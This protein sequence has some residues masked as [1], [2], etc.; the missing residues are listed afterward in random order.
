MV[1]TAVQT[2][3]RCHFCGTTQKG[4]K[5]TSL[6]DENGIPRAIHIPVTAV[7]GK[8]ADI[9]P[10]CLKGFEDRVA[11]AQRQRVREHNEDMALQALR[12]EGGNPSLLGPEMKELVQSLSSRGKPNTQ[13]EIFDCTVGDCSRFFDSEAGRN[14][15]LKG[16]K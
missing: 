1:G 3:R 16:H 7:D 10:G 4:D 15:H 13:R 8:S 14:G 9:T 2:N 12:R 5:F 6:P 11:D